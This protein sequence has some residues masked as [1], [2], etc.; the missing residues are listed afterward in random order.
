MSLEELHIHDHEAGQSGE[1]SR[2]ER[3]ARKTLL[4]GLGLKKVEG[5]TRVTIKRSRNVSVALHFLIR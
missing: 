5:I 3:K 4:E 1:I 2:N